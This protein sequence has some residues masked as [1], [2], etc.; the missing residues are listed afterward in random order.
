VAVAAPDEK[1]ERLAAEKGSHGAHTMPA[2]R[3]RTLH[4]M[5]SEFDPSVKRTAGITTLQ[6]NLF[7]SWLR[8]AFAC[9]RILSFCFGTNHTCMR[10][11]KFPA[12]RAAWQLPG[13]PRSFLR[14]NEE[15]KYFLILLSLCACVCADMQGYVYDAFDHSRI[16]A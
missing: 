10:A 12:V 2:T 14:E 13:T 5:L 7:T 3:E 15:G 6:S 16:P 11:L 9:M 4:L 8:Q 1:L